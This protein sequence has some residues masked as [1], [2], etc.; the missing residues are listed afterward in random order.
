MVLSRFCKILSRMLARITGSPVTRYSSP[1]VPCSFLMSRLSCRQASPS[2][3]SMLWNRNANTPLLPCLLRNLFKMFFGWSCESRF[4]RA[5][6]S[7][8]SVNAL[9]SLESIFA[10]KLPVSISCRESSF[11]LRESL[12]SGPNC[13]SVYSLDIVGMPPFVFKLMKFLYSSLPAFSSGN[14][15]II[16]SYS[17]NPV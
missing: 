11:S 17:G 4:L 6:D 8:M 12:M 13:A 5:R 2:V 10:V 14:S 16:G 3:G 7:L 15:T 1:C 9:S